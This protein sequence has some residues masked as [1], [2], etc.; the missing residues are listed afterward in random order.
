M[1]RVSV[2]AIIRNVLNHRDSDDK[3]ERAS[4]IGFK[5]PASNIMSTSFANLSGGSFPIF[6]TCFAMEIAIS[7]AF[8]DEI[9][10]IA[11]R[12]YYNDY[13]PSTNTRL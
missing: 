4:K 7:M 6:Q 3:A 11:Q 10:E 5:L 2:S 13:Y 1:Q 9:R 12:L 8:W